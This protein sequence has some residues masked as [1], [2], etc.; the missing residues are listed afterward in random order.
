M[1]EA[2]IGP[3]GSGPPGVT[4]V[5][6]PPC[7]ATAD[8][9]DVRAAA[10]EEVR[11]WLVHHRGGAPFLSS[12]D[13]VQLAA[14]LDGGVPVTT[15][16]LAIDRVAARRVAKRVRTPFTLRSCVATVR[17]LQ[18]AQKSWRVPKDL[19]AALA[20]AAPDDLARAALDEL[21]ALAEPDLEQRA[22]AA[23]AVLRRFHERVWDALGDERAALLAAAAEELAPLR[24]ALGA[25]E[26]GRA[27]E[28]LA[29]DRVRARY[30]S[31]SAARVWEEFG[32]G[33]A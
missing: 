30:P 19:G 17:K 26:Y 25:S 23:C 21:A 32:L 5:E 12:A 4:E 20:P 8:S 1:E 13:G 15:I 24:D 10:A 2:T 14:W 11:A 9:A 29:R 3:E 27:C 16:L 6:H 33:L 31:L 22:R 7:A 18:G 28:E